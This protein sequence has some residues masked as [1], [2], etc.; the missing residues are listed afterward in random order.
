[1]EDATHLASANPHPRDAR[2]R[3]EDEGHLYYIDERA[4][5]YTSVTTVIHQRFPVFDA[6]EV[7][8]KMMRG[9]RWPQH[10]LF[11][12]TPDEIKA[13][14]AANAADAAARGTHM[15]EQIEIFMNRWARDGHGGPLETSRELVHFREFM[16][17]HV[18]PRELEPFR[19]EMR[20]FH[21]E[22]KIAG[23][24]DM[25]FRDQDGRLYIY[26]WKRSKE[27]KMRNAFGGRGLGRL[28]HIHDC[29]YEHYSLQLN[30]YRRILEQK[31][32]YEIAGMALAIFHPNQ[33]SY[34]VLPVRRMD[35]EL[36]VIWKERLGAYYT[37]LDGLVF[38]FAF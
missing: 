8:S 7:I 15:H 17:E 24:I 19:T 22:V 32:G 34:V 29:N 2:I 12:K 33:E 38:F 36:D 16:V 35:K 9:R 20:V 4:G 27:I 23:S 14:W 5:E 13:A 31:Y 25:L 37:H 6:D 18:D 10:A 11:G 3:F 26:D 30:V 1:M 21:E 28:G